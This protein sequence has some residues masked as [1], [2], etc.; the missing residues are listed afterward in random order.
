MSGQQGAPGSCSG[1][2]A[3]APPQPRPVRTPAP[4]RPGPPRGSRSALPPRGRASRSYAAPATRLT[5]QTPALDSR[6]SPGP[7]ACSL[8]LPTGD[9]P[10]VK[11]GASCCKALTTE[12]GT[13]LRPATAPAPAVSV[14][15]SGA[16]PGGRLPVCLPRSVCVPQ[17]PLGGGSEPLRLGGEGPHRRLPAAIIPACTAAAGESAAMLR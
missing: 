7:E 4:A 17:R 3:P 2:R 12:P 11:L 15:V 1:A 5:V 8:P 6:P 14:W 16:R 13:G 10:A 9:A